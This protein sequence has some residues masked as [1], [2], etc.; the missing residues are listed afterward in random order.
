MVAVGIA[1]ETDDREG[2]FAALLRAASDLTGAAQV[3]LYAVAGAGLQV[4][5]ATDH[6][7]VGRRIAADELPVGLHGVLTA[8]GRELGTL[9]A[10]GDPARFDAA[11]AHDLAAL[12]RQAGAALDTMRLHE[13]AKRLALTDGLTGLWNRRQLDLRV[14]QEL[15][16]AARFGERFSLVLVDLDDFK[17]V[18]DTHGHPV[19][20]AVLVEVA[21]RLV[22]HTREV[23]VVARFGGEEFV[24]LLPQTDLE[25]ACRVADKVRDEV[26]AVPVETDGLSVAISLSAGVACHPRHGATAAALLAAADEAL[27]RA[28]HTGKN[29]VQAAAG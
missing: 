24:L 27:Y 14:G 9:V 13:E 26:A 6:E 22:T 10:L 17:A 3:A 15:E 11:A 21:Q 19:G 23:D 4:R 2:L 12:A 5:A 1:L 18:N 7:L 8:Q 16:R 25:G 20:D 29:R 28:K